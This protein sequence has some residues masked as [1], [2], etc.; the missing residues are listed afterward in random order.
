MCEVALKVDLSND[1]TY[2]LEAYRKTGSTY[3]FA[4][5]SCMQLRPGCQLKLLGTLA[6]PS[7]LPTSM[8]I[9]ALLVTTYETVPRP[10]V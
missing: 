2:M 3:L 4:Y 10:L 8:L 9:V 1:S 6:F 7:F 5:L